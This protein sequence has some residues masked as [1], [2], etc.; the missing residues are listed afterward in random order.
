MFGRFL[1]YGLQLLFQLEYGGLFGSVEEDGQLFA[2]DHKED[3]L[4]NM[5]EGGDWCA[6]TAVV[7]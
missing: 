6:R 4:R 1:H 2:S 5:C 3:I 7:M